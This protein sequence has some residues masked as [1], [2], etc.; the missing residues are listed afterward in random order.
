MAQTIPTTGLGKH[1]RRFVKEYLAGWPEGWITDALDQ[2]VLL[3]AAGQVDVLAQLD[4]TAKELGVTVTNSRGT[5]TVAPW[6]A[7]ARLARATLAS[8]IKALA[9]PED[10]DETDRPEPRRRN[11]RA[12]NTKNAQQRWAAKRNRG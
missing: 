6:V 5:T 11:Q 1:G 10:E 4:A 3:L 9:Y 12:T 7:E 2:R 8:L